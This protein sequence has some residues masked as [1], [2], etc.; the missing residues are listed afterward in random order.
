MIRR[1]SESPSE[2]G[3]TCVDSG[4]LGQYKAGTEIVDTMEKMRTVWR[5][6]F[7]KISEA[8][9]DAL[10]FDTAGDC[11]ITMRGYR[12]VEHA[13]AKY[14]GS[15]EAGTAESCARAYLTCYI[16]LGLILKQTLFSSKS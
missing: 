4:T 13:D 3:H 10:I 14:Q 15:I 16:Q 6:L 2:E 11:D 5:S 12:V 7:R 8:Q 9:T 1:K